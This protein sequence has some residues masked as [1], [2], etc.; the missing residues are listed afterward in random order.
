[1]IHSRSVLLTVLTAWAFVAQIA[2]AFTA[3]SIGNSR[4]VAVANTAST[5]SSLFMSSFEQETPENT[6]ARIQGLV[7]NHP[8]LVFMKGSQLFPQCGF[9]NTACQILQSFDIEFHSVDVLSDEAVRSGVKDF[10]Q[11]PTIP[12]LYVVRKIS[13]CVCACVCVFVRLFL[14]DCCDIL[15]NRIFIFCSYVCRLLR[16]LISHHDAHA[17]MKL[18]NVDF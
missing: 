11:W 17:N 4:S 13:I 9:S 14:Y 15:Y 12:Q 7:D 1:M 16:S 6:K 5:T 8:V 10:S 18:I 3:T 2:S